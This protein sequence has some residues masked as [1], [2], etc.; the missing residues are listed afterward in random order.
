MYEKLAGSRMAEQAITDLA[1]EGLFGH[2]SGLGHESIGV[3][4]GMAMRHGDAVQPSHRSGMMLAHA[5]GDFSLRDAILSKAGLAPGYNAPRAKD[6]SRTLMVVGLVGSQLPMAVGSAMADRMK[7]DDAVTVCFF[8]DGGANEGAVHEGMNLAGAHR[9]PMVFV[10]E[11]NGWS[12]ST[13]VEEVF[14]GES[15]ASRAAGYGMTGT[16]VDGQDPVAIYDAVEAAIARARNGDGGSIVEARLVR[17]EPH[18]VGIA[19]V[20]SEEEIAK[21]RERD[22]VESLRQMI[23]DRGLVSAEEAA[24]IDSRCQAEID[25][26]VEEVRAA[27]RTGDSGRTFDPAD[28]WNLTYAS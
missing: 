2:H 9:L 22:G 6:R 19:D 4:V 8:G 21:A 13:P 11:N 16:A 20:R 12:V 1:K 27:P 26:A 15:Y 5:R 23:I 18:S 17:W 7:R 25:A 24:Q 14:G 3:A 10:I 28:A